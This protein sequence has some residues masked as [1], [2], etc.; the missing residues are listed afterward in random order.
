MAKPKS[1]HV[2]VDAAFSVATDH[3]Y[4][5]QYLNLVREGWREVNSAISRVLVLTLLPAGVFELLVR[6]AVEKVSFGG[7][8]ITD[9]SMIGKILPLLIACNFYRLSGLLAAEDDYRAVYQIATRLLHQKVYDQ[10]LEYFLMPQA[11][12]VHRP[13]SFSIYTNRSRFDQV[14]NRVS[15]VF[16]YSIYFAIIVFEMYAF[17]F[18]FRR[19]HIEDF[20][21]WMTLGLSFLFIAGALGIFLKRIFEGDS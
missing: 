7:F 17:Y 12:S 9:V 15:M 13:T 19:L 21:L 2:R 6:A 10:D 14:F 20:L 1:L 16:A 18:Q 4:F 5:N 11:L 8:E 3:E